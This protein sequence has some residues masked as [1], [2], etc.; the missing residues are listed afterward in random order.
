MLFFFFLAMSDGWGQDAEFV[1]SWQGPG[2]ILQSFPLSL[3]GAQKRA[4]VTL[5]LWKVYYLT[6]DFPSSFLCTM[7]VDS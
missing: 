5:I 6:Q 1:L 3:H 7:F 4:F 2:R